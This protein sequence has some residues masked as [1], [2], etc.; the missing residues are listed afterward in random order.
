MS[1]EPISYE[2]HLARGYCCYDSRNQHSRCV[3]CPWR[4]TL[5]I[6]PMTVDP[7][8]L[9]ALQSGVVTTIQSERMSLVP[10]L[11]IQNLTIIYRKYEPN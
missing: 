6:P 7:R 3:F 8:I 2:A 11:T 9:V 1:Y 4:P 5:V 10:Q